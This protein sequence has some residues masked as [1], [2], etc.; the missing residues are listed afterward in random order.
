VAIFGVAHDTVVNFGDVALEEI[1]CF[2]EVLVVVADL[3]GAVAIVRI[4]RVADLS[5]GGVIIRL[6]FA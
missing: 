6:K 1:F 2:V 4:D 5:D 3:F